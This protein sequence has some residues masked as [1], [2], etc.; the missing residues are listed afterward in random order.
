MSSGKDS[1]TQSL[2]VAKLYYYE[3]LTTNEI[4]TSLGVSR[5]IVSRL[6]KEAHESGLVEIVI[7]DAGARLNTIEETLREKF[8]LFDVQVVPVAERESAETWTHQVGTYAANYL[9]GFIAPGFTVGVA[10]GKTISAM[11]EQ[12]T[13]KRV[14]NVRFVQLHGSSVSTSTASY[15]GSE[16][17]QRFSEVFDAPLTVFPVP[18]YF[19]FA[20][21]KQTMWKERSIRRVLN[22]RAASNV[23]LFSVGTVTAGE[24]GMPTDE[25]FLRSDVE[26]LSEHHAVGHI[27]TVFFREDGSYTDIPI[28][29]RATGPPLSEYR[30]GRISLCVSSGRDR[31]RALAAALRAGFVTTLILDEPTAREIAAMPAP[32]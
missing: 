19:D 5:P 11:A 23:F 17:V 7:H 28:N 18:A 14:E 32:T 21:T 24:P 20:E 16:T 1:K 27:G 25:S 9:R 31:R 8:S 30:S 22:A 12:L 4:A 6:L 13:P 10:L 29:A 3:K 15:P 2:R 26:S